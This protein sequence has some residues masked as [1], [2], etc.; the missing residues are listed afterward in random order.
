MTLTPSVIPLYHTKT[1]FYECCFVFFHSCADHIQQPSLGSKLMWELQSW[2]FPPTQQ[3]RSVNYSQKRWHKSETRIHR[4]TAKITSPG[5]IQEVPACVV[6]KLLCPQLNH[7]K[8]SRG[9]SQYQQTSEI[10]LTSHFKLQAGRHGESSQNKKI[11]CYW[12]SAPIPKTYQ[13]NQIMRK[14]LPP[15]LQYVS[16]VR[17]KTAVKLYSAYI[18]ELPK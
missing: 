15:P 11:N 1:P 17:K 18:C 16:A 2:K 10:T 12:V 6:I 13:L 7:F 5:V 4:H 3:P 9:D 8:N 14:Q